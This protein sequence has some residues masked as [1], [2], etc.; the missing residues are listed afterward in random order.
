[1]NPEN[2]EHL[3]PVTGLGRVLIMLRRII[4]TGRVS[5][6]LNYRL[7]SLGVFFSAGCVGLPHPS[8]SDAERARGSWPTATVE[9]L[10][11]GRKAYS[12]RCSGCHTLFLPESHTPAEWAKALPEMEEKAKL[13]PGEHELIAQ[14]LQT[15]SSPRSPK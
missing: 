8:P 5:S 3:R 1:M 15:M 14:F 7:L 10:E 11:S 2:T 9:T 4:N 12:A 13:R 6:T